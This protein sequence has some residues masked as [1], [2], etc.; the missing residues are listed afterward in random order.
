MTVHNHGPED[1]PGLACRESVV[2]G[3]L[4]GACLSLPERAVEAAARAIQDTVAQPVRAEDVV[5]SYALA[6][7]ALAAA[8][9]HLEAQALRDF[10]ASLPEAFSSAAAIALVRAD[11]IE[12]GERP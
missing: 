7:P 2:D 11:R 5:I 10:A 12:A 9:P 1:G 8:T 4:R 6:R 3:H